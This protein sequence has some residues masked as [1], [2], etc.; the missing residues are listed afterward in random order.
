MT[1]LT[2]DT[3]AP[4]S[5]PARTIFLVLPPSLPLPRPSIGL[6]FLI[7][8]FPN[9]SP[10]M[11]AHRDIPIKLG[12]GDAGAGLILARDMHRCCGY[13]GKCCGGYKAGRALLPKLQ[14]AFTLN[15]MEGSVHW[16]AR[17]GSMHRAVLMDDDELRRPSSSG[18]ERLSDQLTQ[19]Q[20]TG[21]LMDLQGLRQGLEHVGIALA[22]TDVEKLPCWHRRK[23]IDFDV[24]L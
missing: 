20:G 18:G 2:D 19:S 7:P 22:L 8:S 6:P 12:N 21:G 23:T 13:C 4:A 14:D 10:W 11:Q 17:T 3:L 5:P 9:T 1:F 15:V 16:R 24:S